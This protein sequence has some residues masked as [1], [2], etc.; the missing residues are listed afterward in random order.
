MRKR[1]T[2]YK[3]GLLGIGSLFLSPYF[4]KKK[5]MR[6]LCIVVCMLLSINAFSQ[7]PDKKFEELQQQ[8]AKQ[9]AELDSS[10]KVT[11]SIL[12]AN[13]RRNDSATLAR[14][15]EQNTNNLV[16]FMKE[17]DRKQKQAMWRNLG[18]GILMLVVLV[19]GLLRKRKKK[20]TQ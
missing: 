3:Y 10:S 17:R 11:D 14:S 19:V 16:S 5:I 1:I 7:Q 13:A 12:L 9:R 2:V 15:M 6:K 20:D 4:A 18:I 8:I